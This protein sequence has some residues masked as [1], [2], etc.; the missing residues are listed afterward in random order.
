[1]VVQEKLASNRKA[2]ELAVGAKASSL[3]SGLIFDGD[4]NRM[5]PTH[6]NKSGR[7]YRYYISASL[8]DRG[9]P[10]AGT[11]RV[12]A[13]EVEGLV[14]D[15]IRNLLASQ[16]EIGSALAQLPL[17]ARELHGALERAAEFSRNWIGIPPQEMHALLRSI[18]TRVTLLADRIGITI[19]VGRLAHALGASTTSGTDAGPTIDLS[20]AAALRRSGQGKRLII[21]DPY[22]AASDASLI[23][24]LKEAVAPGS[25][26]LPIPTRR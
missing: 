8:L 14:L 12:P 11:M 10:G 26:C 19:G 2:R 13:S 6:A 4:G 1:V 21:G 15:Q 18:V 20:V 9:K 25:S 24:V 3:L 17:D 16:H 23:D 5:T 22:Q 7:R